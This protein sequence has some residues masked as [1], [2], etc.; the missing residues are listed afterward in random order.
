[1]AGRILVTGATGFVGTALTATLAAE[2]RD[3]VAVGRR[4]TGD[5][6]PDT[7]W[8]PWLGPG[9]DCVVHLAGRAHVMRDQAMD[10]AAAY[11]AV[12]RAATAVLAEQAAAA[13]VRRIVYMSSVKALAESGLDVSPQDSPAPLD[14]YGRSKLAAERALAEAVPGCEIVILRPPLIYG[15]G[16]KGNFLRLIRLVERGLPLPLGSV[17][18]KRSMISLANIVDATA[19]AMHCQPGVYCPTDAVALS[20]PELIRQIGAALGRPARLLPFPVGLLRALA[21]LAGR[22]DMVNRVTGSLTLKGAPPGWSAPQSVEDAV[23]ETV[24]W[25]VESRTSGH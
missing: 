17:R 6:G 4:E 24:A 14:D 10:P 19:T 15:P 16:V 21:D 25:Y 13:G 12:N 11:D 20:T 1:V 3:V 2:G 22:G 9:T 23:A 18:N 7:D 5:L 8:R